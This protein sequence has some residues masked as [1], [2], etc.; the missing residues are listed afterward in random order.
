MTLLQMI[1]KVQKRYWVSSGPISIFTNSEVRS[2]PLIYILNS[3]TV[4]FYIFAQYRIDHGLVAS[5]LFFE[6]LKETPGGRWFSARFP[7][8]TLSLAQ[9]R[10]HM[11]PL[12]FYPGATPS[13]SRFAT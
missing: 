3:M 9:Q 12:P 13:G 6:K 4:R 1:E 8:F 7:F 2:A 10:P 5:P 11:S